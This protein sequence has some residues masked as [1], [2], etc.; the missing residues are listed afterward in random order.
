MNQVIAKAGNSLRA[1]VDLFVGIGALV[2]GG[3]FYALSY[4][5]PEMM[6]RSGSS[7]F[8]PQ[9]AASAIAGLGLLLIIINLIFRRKIVSVPGG[10]QWRATFYAIGTMGIMIVSVLLMEWLGYMIGAA[11]AMAGL[12][13]LYGSRRWIVIAE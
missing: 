12:M 4:T 3:I 8:F 6:T 2:F 11:L 1:H 10:M 5:I 7:R 9:F 13:V